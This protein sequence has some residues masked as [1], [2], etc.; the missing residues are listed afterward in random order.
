[1]SDLQL[2]VVI[3]TEQLH[4]AQDW[5]HDGDDDAHLVVILVLISRAGL[6]LRHIS[7]LVRIRLPPVRGEGLLGSRRSVQK[8]L[9][10]LLGYYGNILH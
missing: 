4:Q 6:S 9:T 1:M 5:L 10:N 2:T 8:L 3:L 7:V